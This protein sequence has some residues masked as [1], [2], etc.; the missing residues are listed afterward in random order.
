MGM[1]FGVNIIGGGFEGV[2][3]LILICW[4]NSFFDILFGY[5]WEFIK[6]FVGV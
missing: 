4:D 3:I 1:G 2:W 6:S 5:E